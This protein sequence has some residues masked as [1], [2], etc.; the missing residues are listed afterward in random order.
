M[1]SKTIIVGRLT[2]DP[3]LRQTTGGVSVVSFSVAV[4]RSYTPKGGERQT[5]FY[6]VVAWRQTAE[7]VCRYFSKGSAILAEGSMESRTYKDKEGND[8]RVWEL[9]ASNVSFVESKASASANRQD[10]GLPPEPP[11]SVGAISAPAAYT[12]GT[13]EDFTEID[14]DDGDLPF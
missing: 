4:N 3:E 10:Y 13:V 9:I 7:F 2:R 6:E 11:A 8:R 12:S 14:D 1:Y 5:D